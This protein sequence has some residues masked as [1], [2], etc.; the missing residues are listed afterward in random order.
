MKKRKSPFQKYPGNA[1][2]AK[3]LDRLKIDATIPFVHG[4]IRG[5]LVNPA[6]VHPALTFARICENK[7]PKD[8][9][10]AD[11]ELLLLALTFLWNDTAVGY[12]MVQKLPQALIC[13]PFTRKDER[14]YNDEIIDLADGFL[15]GFC[16]VRIPKK[17]RSEV[18]ESFFLD[19][20]NEAKMCL[21]WYDNPEEFEK[22]YEDPGLRLEVLK[23]CL[24]M[25]EETMVL[26]CLHTTHASREGDLF[27]G[28]VRKI[29]E[30]FKIGK[31]PRNLDMLT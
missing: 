31:G 3:E 22:E 29:G 5:A 21:R 14:D 23:G 24:H 13:D 27:S 7:D 6:G 28:G 1:W 8:L 2:L 17:Y 11:L 18:C 30:K 4:V 19:I 16:L 10:T 12:N 15:E 20:V 26:M 9:K 25:I